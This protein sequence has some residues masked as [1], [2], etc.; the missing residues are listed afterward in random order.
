MKKKI[1]MAGLCVL[2]LLAS[3]NDSFDA[4]TGNL[5]IPKVNVGAES[6]EVNMQHQGNLVF[7]VISAVPSA[8]SE[9]LAD[10]FDAMTGVLSMPSVDVGADN[11]QVEMMHQGNLVF[12]VTA[13]NLH[14]DATG[15]ADFKFSTDWLN[16]KTLYNVYYESDE[17][18][19][20]LITQIFT[21]STFTIFDSSN[22]FENQPYSITNEGYIYFLSPQ[23]N[24]D[25]EHRWVK[26]IN[27]SDDYIEIIWT[28]DTQQLSQGTSDGK[29]FYYFDLQTAES[30]INAQNAGINASHGCV[31][32]ETWHAA[33]G[34][35]M[36]QM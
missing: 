23:N 25:T 11:Y 31:S 3:A 12:A 34:H 19:W 10:T 20:F 4:V 9:M 15:E 22:R 7:K 32:P 8:N 1:L 16:G 18:Q 36:I 35:C 17:E 13:A 27:N 21:D 26:A 6:Y 28:G 2:P 24:I 30:F 14:S 5:L 29:E 33:M